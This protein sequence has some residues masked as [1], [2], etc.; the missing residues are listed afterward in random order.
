MATL[1]SVS[2]QLNGTAESANFNITLNISADI[3]GTIKSFNGN[4]IKKTGA[5]SANF[6]GSGNDFNINANQCS[7]YVSEIIEAVKSAIT[8]LIT[9]AT[10]AA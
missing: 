7:D 6:N 4:A 2:K 9:A 1:T 8:E 3:D 10:T 5:G